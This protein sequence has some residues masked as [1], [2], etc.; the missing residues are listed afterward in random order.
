[1]SNQQ[2]TDL[3]YVQKSGDSHSWRPVSHE[4]IPPHILEICEL[5]FPC[6]HAGIWTAH[7]LLKKVIPELTKLTPDTKYHITIVAPH[8]E[9]FFNL[10]SPRTIASDSA[11]PIDKI[12]IPLSEGF[13]A[14][15]PELYTFV[16]G[17]ATSIS[18]E[19]KAVT[20]NLLESKTDKVFNYSTLVVATGSKSNSPLWFNTESSEFTKK[21][22]S[23]L[24][25]SLKSAETVLIGGGGAVGVETAAEIGFYLKKKITLLSGGKR[26]LPRLLP[27]NSASAESKLKALGVEIVNDLRVTASR[28]VGAKTEV[29]LSDGTTRTV[30]VYI[31]A[32]GPT[33]NNSHLPA[34]WLDSTGKIAVDEKTFRVV[35]APDVYAAGDIAS[36]SDGTVMNPVTF[37][38]AV[39]GSSIAVDMSKALGVAS[40]VPQKEYKPMKDSQFVTLGPKGGVAQAFGWKLPSFAVWLIK[41]RTMFIEKAGP[42]LKGAEI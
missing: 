17:K 26:L 31:D 15:A 40:P 9:W 3:K 12:F 13:T 7:F 8:T 28:T 5:T 37:G 25:T 22:F 39:I 27:A 6:S 14:Y 24:Q 11:A 35:G 19:N 32:T 4:S 33:P 16:L 36:N 42:Q 18:P 21:I 20:V 41:S 1:L 38:T 23:E 29:T 10:S 2:P 34:A 30:D